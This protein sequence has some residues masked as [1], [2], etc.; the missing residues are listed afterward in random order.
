MRLC[1]FTFVTVVALDQLTKLCV[2][3]FI[4]LHEARVVLTPCLDICHVENPGAAWGMFAGHRW[5]LIAV[6]LATG[7]VFIAARRTLLAGG[8]IGHILTGL[9]FG[10][11]V[12]NVIDRL[13]YGTVTDFIHVHWRA[14]W[15]FPAFNVAD[16]ALCIAAGLFVLRSFLESRRTRGAANGDS[17]HA[18]TE[19]S[20]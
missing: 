13:L 10:G 3:R 6:S 4:A 8:R 16:S 18:A 2:R 20:P 7:L 19:S 14:V 1:G 12:G 11:L 9:L 5:P 17:G 15:D